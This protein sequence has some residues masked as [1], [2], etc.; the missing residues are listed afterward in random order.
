[1]NQ[2]IK[3][4]CIMVMC[5]WNVYLYG[6]VVQTHVGVLT[7]LYGDVQI[8]YNPSKNKKGD[9]PHAFYD[10]LYYTFKKAVIGDKVSVGS[11]IKTGD[12]SR[13]KIV[14][15]NGDQ[16][17]ISSRSFYRVRLD[18]QNKKVQPI[19]EVVFGALRAII[20]H[21]G[22]RSNMQFRTRSLSMGVRGTDFCILSSTATGASGV[23]VL[24]GKVEVKP[25][26]VVAKADIKAMEVPAGYQAQITLPSSRAGSKQQNTIDVVKDKADTQVQD[27]QNI[28]NSLSPIVQLKK[29]TKQDLIAI[30]EKTNIKSKLIEMPKEENVKNFIADL[31]KKALDTTI[32]D[33][34]LVDQKL[35]SEISKVGLNINS[36]E[37]VSTITVKALFDKA[38]IEAKPHKPSKYDLDVLKED[39]YQKYFKID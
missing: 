2:I 8:L 13:A 10:N 15:N 3:Y 1:M 11:I 22:P 37:D 16:F 38:P 27:S 32:E 23:I 17:I 9:G 6:D 35:Y 39:V 12:S 26:M 20:S 30:Q 14:Y 29:A 31:E 36:S 18:A 19:G 24:R 7:K 28:Q 25:I 34:K 33:I 21:N 5:C 4:G